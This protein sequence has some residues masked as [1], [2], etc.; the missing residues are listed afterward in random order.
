MADQSADA[1][2]KI[3]RKFDMEARTIHAPFKAKM[4]RKAHG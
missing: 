2:R 1:L 4:P 3:N